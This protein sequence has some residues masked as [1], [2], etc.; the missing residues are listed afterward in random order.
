M[1]INIGAVTCMLKSVYKYSENPNSSETARKILLDM[2]LSGVNGEV[3]KKASN[4]VHGD[5]MKVICTGDFFKAYIL[6]DSLNMEA[7]GIGMSK[8]LSMTD[9]DYDQGLEPSDYLVA[10]S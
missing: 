8:F 1:S 6:A 7:L 3:Y 2:S 4:G 10:K 9:S 5:L